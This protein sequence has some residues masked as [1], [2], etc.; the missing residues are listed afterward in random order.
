MVITR[1]GIAYTLTDDEL[2]AAYRE[3]LK[4]IDLEAVEINMHI[5]LSKQEYAFLQD[6]EEFIA[7]AAANVRRLMHKRNITFMAAVTASVM[8]TKDKYLCQRMPHF[9]ALHIPA[10]DLV[11]GGAA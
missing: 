8:E 1:N 9:M 6:D 2:Y 4:R 10:R 5:S 3:Q 7:E 11:K